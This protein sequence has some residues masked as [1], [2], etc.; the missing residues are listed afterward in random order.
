MITCS[1][2][3]VLNY[4]G[5]CAAE[6]G[7]RIGERF[8]DKQGYHMTPEL[9]AVSACR[10]ITRAF[11]HGELDYP[12]FRAKMAVA[13]GPLDPLDWALKELDSDARRE[14]TMYVE[15][16]GGE[17]GETEERIPRRADWKYGQCNEPYG[18]VDVLEYRKRLL[19]AF[20][21]ILNQ[22]V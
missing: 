6:G 22:N 21:Q 17:F 10:E 20:G 19:E 8:G 15:W 12:T 14:A 2:A 9:R 11:V 1:T 3:H 7:K 4:L 13:M 18:W 16:L 5:G